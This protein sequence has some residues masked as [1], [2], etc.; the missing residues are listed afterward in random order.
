MVCT[1]MLLE[2]QL[3]GERLCLNCIGYGE[4]SLGRKADSG[5]SFFFF[6]S[7]ERI[8]FEMKPKERPHCLFFSVI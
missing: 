5:S 4:V 3:F 2:L 7:G 6:L 1:F 8:F